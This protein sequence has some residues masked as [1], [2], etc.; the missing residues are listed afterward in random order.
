[1]QWHDFWNNDLDALLVALDNY[2]EKE[3]RDRLAHGGIKEEG[4]KRRKAIK[5]KD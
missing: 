1:M 2:E 5:K 3:E 4:G